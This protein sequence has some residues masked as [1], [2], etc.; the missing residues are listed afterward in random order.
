[1]K[2]DKLVVTSLATEL[3][4]DVFISYKKTSLI[5]L[6]KIIVVTPTQKCEML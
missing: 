1:M 5:Y 2:K 3:L 6:R 4:D